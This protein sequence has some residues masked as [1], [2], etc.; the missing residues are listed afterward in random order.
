MLI[1]WV[2]VVHHNSVL[3]V[4]RQLNARYLF[5]PYPQPLPAGWKAHLSFAAALLLAGW[6]AA[7]W[8]RPLALGGAITMVILPLEVHWLPMQLEL[9]HYERFNAFY[10][11]VAFAVL[12]LWLGRF[13]QT[14]LGYAAI[15]V[16]MLGVSATLTTRLALA[17]T[18]YNLQ[19]YPRGPFGNA[20]QDI[21]LLPAYRW[22]RKN[23][24]PDALF[25]VD[26][27]RYLFALGT[28]RRQV[29]H[30]RL[31]G[32]ALSDADVEGLRQLSD[33]I[34]HGWGGPSVV[35]PLIDRYHPDY[36]LWTSGTAK[37][38]ASWLSHA[39]VYQDQECEVWKL[40]R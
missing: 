7:P 34:I 37:S 11:V 39:V 25:V 6:R 21:S 16:G 14:S 13:A 19:A 1:P 30:E 12:T 4:T 20:S 29:L 32:N 27:K 28:R 9:M 5:A 18:T 36:V 2:W 24:P 22:I 15:L 38:S 10:A 35:Q 26:V 17:N 3:E 40:L 33:G 31:Y 8:W 23:T